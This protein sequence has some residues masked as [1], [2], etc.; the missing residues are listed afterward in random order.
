M[1][2][3]VS[4]DSKIL[5]KLFIIM[6]Q[7]VNYIFVIMTK[8]PKFLIIKMLLP[9]HVEIFGDFKTDQRVWSNVI[10]ITFCGSPDIKGSN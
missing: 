5:N 7:N 10:S 6:E 8:W 9:N 4:K 1:K 3:K 2:K